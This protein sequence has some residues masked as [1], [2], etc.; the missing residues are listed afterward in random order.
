MRVHVLF[1]SKQKHVAARPAS[2]LL[3]ALINVLL[4]GRGQSFSDGAQ[5]VSEQLK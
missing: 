2:F 1:L 5:P 3:S 4:G